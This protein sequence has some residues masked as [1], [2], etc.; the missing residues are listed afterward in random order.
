MSRQSVYKRVRHAVDKRKHKIILDYMKDNWDVVLNASLTAM[1]NMKIRD[2][3]P[4][5]WHIVFGK[6]A[7]KGKEISE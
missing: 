7:K 6:K 1:R 2:R 4:L 5:A 3:L